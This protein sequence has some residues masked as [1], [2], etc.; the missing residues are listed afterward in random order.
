MDDQSRSAWSEALIVL[1]NCLRQPDSGMRDAIVSGRG[2]ETIVETLERVGVD[3]PTPPSVTECDLT[4]A[5]EA[6]FG[7]FV[8]PFAPPA[9]SPY[10]EWYEGREGLM[11]GPP[12]S[13]MERRYDA[14]DV[15]IPPSYP[16]DHVAL[17]LEYASL[18]LEAGE[19]DE[20]AAFVEEEL[21]WID[22]FAELVDEA[23]ADAPFHRWCV[24]VLTRTVADLRG[25]LDVPAPSQE[26]IDRM[27]ERGRQNAE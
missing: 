3:V 14:L 20:A 13:A 10:K 5:Y 21:D 1:S 16:P 19:L 4:E 2:R 8:T 6:L 24:D 22:A 9:A 7:A 12:A 17:E 26:R 18:L 25:E 27:A 15:D 23:S 11:G